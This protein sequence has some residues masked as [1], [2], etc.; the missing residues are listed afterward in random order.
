MPVDARRRSNRRCGADVRREAELKPGTFKPIP[1]TT[2]GRPIDF[3]NEIDTHPCLPLLRQGEVIAW[4]YRAYAAR[5]TVLVQRCVE[6]DP[7]IEQ[8][9]G[10]RHGGT[11]ETWEQAVVGPSGKNVGFVPLRI[12]DWDHFANPSFCGGYIAYWGFQG[13][14]LVPSIYDV[15]AGRRTTSRSL[16]VVTME[17]DDAYF[18]ATPE[19]NESCGVASFDGRPVEKQTTRLRSGR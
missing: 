4:L 1:G 12:P 17:T 7:S 18:L 3:E 2:L 13:H 15:S 14:T 6:F 8:T 5:D 11:Q 10:N 19:W 9:L 16:G